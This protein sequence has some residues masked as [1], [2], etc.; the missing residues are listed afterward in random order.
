MLSSEFSN[1]MGSL[2]RRLEHKVREDP[3]M[4]SQVAR[5]PE[6]TTGNILDD[7]ESAIVDLVALHIKLT[8]QLRDFPG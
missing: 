5:S 7:I 2:I 8:R 1:E 6:W 4:A 3:E